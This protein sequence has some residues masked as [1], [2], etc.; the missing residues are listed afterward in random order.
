MERGVEKA[1]KESLMAASWELL[2]PTSKGRGLLVSEDSARRP[3]S[4]R[5]RFCD[6]SDKSSWKKKKPI[7]SFDQ[8]VSKN[9]FN[10]H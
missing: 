8:I 5:P 6:D 4:V 1:G 3:A 9:Y 7:Q 2:L 10:T